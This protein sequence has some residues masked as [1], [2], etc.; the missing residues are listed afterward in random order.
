MKMT[1]KMTKMKMNKMAK[2]FLSK[3]L[4]KG[5][6]AAAWAAAAA[7]LDAEAMVC[8]NELSTKRAMAMAKAIEWANAIR[9]QTAT[10]TSTETPTKKRTNATT[11]SNLSS[12]IRV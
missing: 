9:T 10:L 1:K 12:L 8:V 6:V 2:Y 11:H 7:R 5:P 4:S 3:K